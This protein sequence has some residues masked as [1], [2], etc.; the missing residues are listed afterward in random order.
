MTQRFWIS[1]EKLP[2]TQRDS[3]QISLPPWPLFSG[4]LE[5]ARG[6]QVVGGKLWSEDI[7]VETGDQRVVETTRVN[8]GSVSAQETG[9]GQNKQRCDGTNQHERF[10]KRLGFKIISKGGAVFQNIERCKQLVE[11]KHKKKKSTNKQSQ[12]DKLTLYV[13]EEGVN[14]CT[15]TVSVCVASLCTS[16]YNAIYFQVKAFSTWVG[17]ASVYN[18]CL[19][20]DA[21]RMQDQSL[22]SDY[23]RRGAVPASRHAQHL[24][25]QSVMLL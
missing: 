8:A 5:P 13:I 18:A 24:R 20:L 1:T 19:G 4:E 10:T 14:V 11:T 6:Q 22:L 16:R 9:T 25:T 3:V 15:H 21:E 12:C 2:K 23:R 17:V 7:F